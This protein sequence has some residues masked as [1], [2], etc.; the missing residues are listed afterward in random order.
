M[1]VTDRFRNSRLSDILE[2]GRSPDT[3]GRAIAQAVSRQFP[4]AAARVRA[5]IR[6]CG[7]CGGQ[8][9]TWVGFLRVLWFPC[10]FAFHRLLHNNHHLSSGAGTIDQTVAAVPSG[11]GLTPWE[12]INYCILTPHYVFSICSYFSLLGYHSQQWLH[13]YN[14]TSC[15][16]VTNINNNDAQRFLAV[17]RKNYM[18]KLLWCM[19]L[20]AS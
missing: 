1:T 9:G 4:T 5:L 2:D 11:L 17:V 15:F 14:V 16:L 13:Q 19:K 10:H 6:S 8:S 3:Q 20:R 7:I 12:K 18:F